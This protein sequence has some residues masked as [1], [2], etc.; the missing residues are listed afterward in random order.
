MIYNN[1]KKITLR[2]LPKS[3]IFKFE[4]HLRYFIYLSYIGKN[5]QCNIC[6]K[7]LRRFITLDND[8]LCP[9]CGS[10]QRNRQLYQLL[11]TS[12]LKPKSRILDFSPSRSQYRLLR[13][14]KLNYTASDLSG[15][16]NADVAYD[17]TA[18]PTEDNTFDLI[19]CYHILE[20]VAD[21]IR[22]MKELFRTVKRGGHCIIQTPFKEGEIYEDD[23]V[24]TPEGRTK[25]FG[26][27]DH[28][29]IYSIKGLAERLTNTGFKVEIKTILNKSNN[30]LGLNNKENILICRKL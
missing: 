8:Q 3:L 14:K 5:Y 9:R 7:N 17:I 28:L 22:A 27:S 12:Y 6:Q 2:L 18:I 15:D 4:Y 24:N 16:F 30:S 25:H 11:E 29:R 23:S 1:I 19:I 26:Q 20:H 10:L 21:D 13:T